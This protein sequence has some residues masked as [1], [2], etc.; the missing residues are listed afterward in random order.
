MRVN[1]RACQLREIVSPSNARPQE[2]SNY[3]RLD[4]SFGIFR[5]ISNQITKAN[6]IISNDYW[7]RKGR[8]RCVVTKS[9]IRKPAEVI[10]LSR[11]SRS[12]RGQR[13]LDE[14]GNW[15]KACLKAN[16]K[17][18]TTPFVESSASSGLSS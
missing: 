1:V 8:L 2:S 5:P 14:N 4:K 6:R 15:L 11:K 12:C 10:R 13:M 16:L 3:N 7:L 9:V 17:P 18:V